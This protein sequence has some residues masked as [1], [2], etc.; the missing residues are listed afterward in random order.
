MND[1]RRLLLRNILLRLKSND[2]HGCRS[3]AAIAAKLEIDEETIQASKP[4]KARAGKQKIDADKEAVNNLG[5]ALMVEV[6]SLTDDY[7]TASKKKA[8]DVLKQID[9]KSAS[10]GELV[11]KW[12]AHVTSKLRQMFKQEWAGLNE[13]QLKLLFVQMSRQYFQTKEQGES[14]GA[15]ATSAGTGTPQASGSAAGKGRKRTKPTVGDDGEEQT[16]S[17]RRRAHV[18]PLQSALE[19]EVSSHA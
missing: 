19:A 2:R 4:I 12:A 8:T 1:G 7:V 5:E 16:G 3:T 13:A 9:S 18:S 6:L 10:R 11:K 15:G 14:P 17:A